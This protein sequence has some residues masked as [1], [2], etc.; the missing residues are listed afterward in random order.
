M[1]AEL[2][3]N[4][5]IP[6]PDTVEEEQTVKKIPMSQS[7]VGEPRQ[8]KVNSKLDLREAK[9]LPNARKAL[10]SPVCVRRSTW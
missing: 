2:G 7:L 3:L 6:P 8:A 10:Q 1:V 5:V 9:H 4:S